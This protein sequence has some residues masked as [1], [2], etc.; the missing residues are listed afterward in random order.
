[1]A[2]G[3]GNG[4]AATV[5]SERRVDLV[6]EGGGVKG[7]GLVGAFS[8]LEERGYEPQNIAG[9]SAGSI[10]ATLIA[11][12][13]SA[14]ELHELV[15]GLD[16]LSFEDRAW[17]DKMPLLGTPLS[18]LKDQGIFEGDAFYG[19]IHDCLAAKGVRTFSDLRSDFVD[20]ERYR[21]RVNVIASDVT[22]HRLLVLPQDARA[23]G[24]DPDDLDV[25]LAVRMSMSIPFFFE[26]VRMVDPLTGREHLIVDGGVLSNFPIWL[27]DSGGEP[28]WPTFGLLLVEPDPESPLGARIPSYQPSPRWVGGT[29]G[30]VK[31]LV[32]T[33]LEA[34]DR[35]YVAK[36]NFARTIP[37]KTLGVGTTEFDLSRE[38]ADALFESGRAA[39]LD[40]LSRWDFDAYVAEFRTGKRQ[41]RRGEISAALAGTPV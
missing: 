37:I 26:P 23:F 32:Q 29:I 15:L 30:Y 14:A 10:L 7:I 1:M 21:Y 22:A 25:A 34:H 40:F 11:A 39:A 35:L 20:E 17:E 38:R 8:V 31:S 36:A 5:P 6:F 18:V 13:Y 9:T 12:R 4:A 24:I 33:M 27:F 28:D 19:W 2:P 41:T 3:V 16:F